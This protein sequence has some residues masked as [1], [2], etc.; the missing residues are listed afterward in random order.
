MSLLLRAKDNHSA[1]HSCP[2]YQRAVSGLTVLFSAWFCIGLLCYLP[3]NGGSGLALPF[4]IFCWLVMATATLWLVLTLP[5]GALRIQ[6]YRHARWSGWTWLLPAGALLWS[7]PLLWSPS[8]ESRLESLPH[9]AALWGLLGFLWLLRRL[10]LRTLRLRHWLTVLWCAA[11]LQAL[12]GFLQVTML[13]K[14]GGFTGNRPFG[15]FQQANV[16]ASFL[17][18]GLACLLF[19]QLFIRSKSFLIRMV[20]GFATV[21][22][23]FVLMLLQ[24][25]AG[26]LGASCAALVLS[27]VY[28]KSANTLRGLILPWLLI[29]A[30]IGLAILLQ[31]GKLEFLNTLGISTQNLMAMRDTSASTQDRWYILQNTWQ[32]ILQHPWMGSGYG[33]FE[34]AFA[35]Q[36]LSSGGV[37]NSAT[38]IH[39]HNE[40]MYA[41]AEGGL[42]ALS[43]MLLM[44]AGIALSL[45]QKGGL[46]W[47][48][49]ALLLP[50]AVHMNLEFPLYQSVPHGMALVIVLSLVLAPYIP[51]G[52]TLK[53]E[54]CNMGGLCI[55]IREEGLR[56]VAFVTGLI[57]LTFMAG[58]LQ[59]Q[60]ALVAVERQGMYPLVVDESGTVDKLWNPWSLPTRLDFDRHISLLMRYNLTRDAR[61]LTQ[62]DGW[63]ADYLTRHNDPNMMASRL[64]IART[65]TPATWPALCHH[66]HL[67]W[68]ADERFQCP[69]D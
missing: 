68:P 27:V 30:G 48:G 59:T 22:L 23:P 60:Q 13:A 15:I 25:R 4:N 12:F 37:Y 41:W 52:E 10:P 9:V 66:A 49:I 5:A 17:A 18:T 58:A 38:L 50:I 69:Q 55:C 29:G 7:A 11:L 32:M 20:A 45:W 43:G 61:L 63:A 46:R 26:G 16:Q 56:A 14:L 57:V 42:V 64:M 31:H 44:I 35:Q 33:S 1:C 65:L 19:C 47:G 53:K 3:D 36:T 62:F 39:P 6:V 2:E 21:F 40:L 34:A 51:A 24:S 8:A 28:L 67:Q 54:Q